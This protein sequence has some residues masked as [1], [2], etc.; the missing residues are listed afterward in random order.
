MTEIDG[1]SAR[2]WVVDRVALWID[3][4]PAMQQAASDAALTAVRDEMGS[5]GGDPVE[6]YEQALNGG[7]ERSGYVDVIGAAVSALVNDTLAGVAYP[8][9]A[10][11][12]DRATMWLFGLL[13]DLLDLT[14][15]TQQRMFGE[16]YMPDLADVREF[17]GGD[18][19]DE[20]CRHSWV[21][22][23]MHVHDEDLD[24]VAA[25]RQVECEYCEA[26]YPRA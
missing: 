24:A 2:S 18:E 14:D 10:E 22:G 11:R 17:L 9:G 25:V 15:G 20:E 6:R 21:A 26:I 5:Y 23:M 7:A 3:N 12:P 16:R 4:D 13:G 1:P 19:D 8:V